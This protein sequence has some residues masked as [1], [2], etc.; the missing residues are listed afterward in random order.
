MKSCT[1]C[2]VIKSI[3]QGTIWKSQE[4]NSDNI[5]IPLTLFFDDVEVNN[6]LG[7][8][9]GLS[10]IG[11]VYCTISCLPP[12]Y[13][14][15]LE[16]IFLLQIHK[17][18]DYKC[19]GN[20]R[21]FHNI[22]KQLTDLENNGLIVNVYGKEYKIFFNLIYIAGDNLGLNSI[23]GFNKSFNSMYS[24]RI[25]TASKTEYH[26]Q[27]V[28]NSELIRK[29]ES[30]SEH[31]SNKMFGIQELCTFNKIPAFH[32]LTNISIDPMHD[33]LEGVCRYDMG[34][35][36]NNFINVE[37]FFTLQHLNNRLSNYE[38]ISCDKN[39]IPILQVDSI[40]NKLII[41]SASEMLFL[42][43]NFCLLIGNLIP[44][45]NKFWKLYLLLRKIVYI[46]ILDTLTLNTRHLLEIYIIKYLKLHVNL[47][48]NQLKPKHHNLIH[49][50]RIIEKYGPLKNLSCMRFEAK[51]K[52]IIAYS[53]TMSS[54]TNISY[55]LALKHQ[56][57]LCYRFI[58]N[59]GFVNRISH[60]TTTGNF[61]DTKE[62]LCLK[63]TITL[64]E[65]YK[66]FQCFNWIQLYGT[67][68]E[69]NNIIRTNKII[70]NG[71]IAF[72]KINVIMLDSINHKVYFVYTH[73]LVIEYSEHLTA[74]EL[75]LTKE[76]ECESQDNLKDY[77][78]YVTHVLND[79][80][81]IAKNDF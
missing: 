64:S 41:V 2:S 60:G 32:L 78:T 29:I 80:I 42:V 33:L 15:M 16:N 76:I 66:N 21:I 28:E 24:C 35:I 18:T 44:I 11:T 9:K 74:Y 59:E 52:Q 49:Y 58:C 55:S 6:P 30:Y 50:S 63:S 53:K 45:K 13:A 17:Y 14:S 31:C 38:R 26:K 77:K 19:F 46:T 62:W 69:I 57:K 4:I 34:K 20:E 75:E 8:H 37:K 1:D 10:K 36:F 7:S 5:K 3:T 72:G 81:Y 23:L 73:F 43:N 39:I 47:F 70:D 48:E 27:F 71:P 22:I 25:C 65:N 61:N 67:K 40:K 56:M 79:K 12:E 51:H 54:R 68:Y